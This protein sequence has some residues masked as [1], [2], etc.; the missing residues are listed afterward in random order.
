MN[1]IESLE[2]RYAV[3]KFDADKSLTENQITTLKKAFN[4]KFKARIAK[5][6]YG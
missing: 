3:K 1:V 4:L 5:T 2:W 6:E